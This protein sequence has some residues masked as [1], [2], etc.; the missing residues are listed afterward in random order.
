MKLKKYEENMKNKALVPDESTPSGI[1]CT[2][3]KCK[4]EM[5]IT[6]PVKV[7]PQ[8]KELRRAVCRECGWR[9]WV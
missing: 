3:K 7:H 2:E 1:A 8:L 6:K 5:M 4:G 9:G